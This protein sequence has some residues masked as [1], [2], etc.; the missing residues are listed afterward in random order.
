MEEDRQFITYY[1]LANISQNNTVRKRK[2]TKMPNNTLANQSAEE[3][4]TNKKIG[5]A[6]FGMF[7]AWISS[8]TAIMMGIFNS[9][10]ST[11]ISGEM[12][13]AKSVLATSIIAI[14]IL[15]FNDIIGGIFCMIW[16]LINGKGFKE[17]KRMINFKVSW[18]ML[19]SAIAAGPLATGLQ[20]SSY[21]LCGITYTTAVLGFSPVLT[22]IL[23]RFV[24]K[25]NLSIRAWIGII[26]VFGGVL[27]SCFLGKPEAAGSNFTIGIILACLCPIGFALEGMFSTYAGDLIDPLEGCAFYRSICSGIMGLVAMVILSAATGMMSVFTGTVSCIF[28]NPMTL[29]FTILMG[30]NAFLS[31]ST[32]YVGFNKCGPARCLAIVNTMPVWSIPLGLIFAKLLKG[33]YEYSVTMPAIAGAVVVVVGVI[34]I[35]AKPSELFNLRDVE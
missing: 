8:L 22:A 5:I 25:E 18:M 7:I 35:V 33:Y 9:S 10:A 11:I 24:F 31:Y 13:D 19:L 1:Q 20:M 16:N 17:F 34:L 32:T 23:S 6:K 4:Y 2:E 21:N 26:L 28:T 3:V 29:L 15:G 14:T 12:T 30:F 27:V